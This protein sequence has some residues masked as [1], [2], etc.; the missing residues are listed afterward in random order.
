MIAILYG[1][2]LTTSQRPENYLQRSRCQVSQGVFEIRLAIDEVRGEK[3][4]RPDVTCRI[5]FVYT[6]YI[7]SVCI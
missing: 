7:F 5:N 3:G 6:V 4:Y 1:H 2:R